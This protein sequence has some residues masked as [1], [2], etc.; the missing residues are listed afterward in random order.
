MTLTEVR[1]VCN[2]GRR[3]GR[4][5]VVLPRAAIRGIV[6]VMTMIHQTLNVTVNEELTGVGQAGFAGT[7]AANWEASAVEGTY[8]RTGT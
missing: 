7:L 5:A 4:R 8:E 1:V 2:T 3:A 6:W